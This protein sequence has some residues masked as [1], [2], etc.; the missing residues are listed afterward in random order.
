MRVYPDVY[1]RR[2]G[3]MLADLLLLAWIAGWVYAGRAVDQLVLQLDT[4]ARGVIN[5]GRTFDSWIQSF[6]QSVPQ[7]IPY[8]SDA[9]HRAALAL[10]QHSGDQLI[11]AGQSGSRAIHTLALVLGLTVAL[12]PIALGLLV[13]VPRRLRLIADMR[14]IHI[15]VRR[16]LSRPELSPQMLEILAGRAIYTMPY[17]R[18]LQYSQNPAADWYA[19]RFE[20][21]ARAEMESHGLT[22]ERYFGPPLTAP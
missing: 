4:L 17:H 10:Q 13:F 14:G 2:V 5:A 15:T 22:V 18:L 1:L 8:V 12:L 19:R 16:A 20:P 9:L 3:W 7:G 21:L 11:A 6:Q